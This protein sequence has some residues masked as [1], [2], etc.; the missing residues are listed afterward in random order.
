MNLYQFDALDST[1]TRAKTLIGKSAS[2]FCVRATTQSA[3]RGQ[4]AKKWFSEKGNYFASF[5]WPWVA[6]FQKASLLSIV[7]AC[8]LFDVFESLKI[9]G[10]AFKWPNDV[11]SDSKKLAGILLEVE[12][13]HVII[14]IGV[15]IVSNPNR[16]ELPER[17]F[18]TTKL[19]D[20]CDGIDIDDFHSRFEA[21]LIANIDEFEKFGFDNFRQRIRQCLWARADLVYEGQNMKKLVRILDVD[22]EGGLEIDGPDGRQKIYSGDFYES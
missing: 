12:R 19:S 20:L 2:P 7:S 8:A 10:L 21:A 16:D 17:A 11:L 14:G 22:I 5:V 6:D 9:S 1:Q 15:N 4:G 18:D 13:Q 3:G